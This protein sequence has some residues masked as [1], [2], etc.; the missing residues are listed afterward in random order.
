MK[1]KT[2]TITNI[3]WDTDGGKPKLP[4]ELKVTVPNDLESYEEIEEFISDEISNM[5]GYCHKGFVTT[6]EIKE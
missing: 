4:K 5:T 2:Y 6:L 1:N 3:E